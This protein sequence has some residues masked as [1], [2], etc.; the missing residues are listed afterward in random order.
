MKTREDE[1]SGWTMRA[2][3]EQRA[4]NYAGKQD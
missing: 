3:A 4:I 2:M 1:E